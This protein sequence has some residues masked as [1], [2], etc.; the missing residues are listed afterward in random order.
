MSL[1]ITKRLILSEIGPSDAPFMLELMNT[2]TWKRFI[3]DRNLHSEEDARNYIL[4]RLMPSYALSGFGFYLC[5]LKENK[6]PI[7]ICGIVKRDALEHV[8]IGFAFLP[9]YE[10]KGLGF[11]SASAVMLYAQHTLGIQTIAGITNADNKSSIALLKKLGLR[12]QKMVLLPNETEEIML[13]VN[14]F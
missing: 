10:G 7:G 8:D 12:Y 5:T 13:F 1:P 14:Q 4:N 6:T 9:Q 11:E 2:P 3:G